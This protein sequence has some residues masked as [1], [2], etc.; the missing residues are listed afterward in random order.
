MIFARGVCFKGRS[1]KEKVRRKRPNGFES[2]LHMAKLL[3]V[4]S[5][6]TTRKTINAF[7][8][9]VLRNNYNLSQLAI[10][11]LKDLFRFTPDL[12]H[13]GNMP[14]ETKYTGAMSD[15]SI[16][17]NFLEETT[18]PTAFSVPRNDGVSR[19]GGQDSPSGYVFESVNDS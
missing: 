6:V 13:Q 15:D 19:M 9:Q 16:N 3:P 18:L 4:F 10:G 2:K 8:E 12:A 7:G 1:Y 5:D 11:L 14:D 17:K